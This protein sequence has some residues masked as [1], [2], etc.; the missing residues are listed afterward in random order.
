M[1]EHH[2]PHTRATSRRD[3]LKLLGVGAA[4]G[5]GAFSHPLQQ[6]MA[7]TSPTLAGQEAFYRF[8]IGSINATLIN[9]GTLVL[10]HAPTITAAHTNHKHRRQNHD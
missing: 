6:A 10:N 5:L 8:K 2:D 3:A 7:Q 1:I 9:D 4:A